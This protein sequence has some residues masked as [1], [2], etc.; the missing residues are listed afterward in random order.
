[1]L[2]EELFIKENGA[3]YEG[4]LS[5]INPPKLLIVMKEPNGDHLNCFWIKNVIKNVLSDPKERGEQRYFKILGAFA[6]R[7]VGESDHKTALEQCAFINLYPFKGKS[8][9]SKSDANE[10]YLALMKKW[11]KEFS[12][13]QG[14]PICK[15]DLSDLNKILC[16]RLQIIKDALEQKIPVAAH[17]QIANRLVNTEGYEL[18][19]IEDYVKGYA[20]YEYKNGTKV[21][22]LPHPANPRLS[23]SALSEALGGIKL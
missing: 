23:Y 1:M 9:Q 15:K 7:I 22:A 3:F 17:R 20:C 2:N 21:Y 10:S 18:Q 13:K 16:N 5:E 11:D 8:S 6:Q 4:C 14:Q 19:Q 12:P